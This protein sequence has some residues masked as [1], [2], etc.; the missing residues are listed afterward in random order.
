MDFIGN[1]CLQMYTSHKGIYEHLLTI[2]LNFLV[3]NEIMSRKFWLLIN[4]DP[5]TKK[6][7]ST[8]FN[9]QQLYYI[10]MVIHEMYWAVADP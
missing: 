4:I 8:V 5:H 6:K 7:D 1:P 3:T 2:Y 9:F 10:K